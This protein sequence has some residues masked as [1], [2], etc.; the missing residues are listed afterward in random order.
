[1]LAHGVSS[2]EHPVDRGQRIDAP[3]VSGAKDRDE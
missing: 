2:G 1:M 3:D